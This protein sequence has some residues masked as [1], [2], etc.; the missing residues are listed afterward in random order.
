MHQMK[1]L[2]ESLYLCVDGG[3]GGGSYN[4]IFALHQDLDKA[5]FTCS[6]TGKVLEFSGDQRGRT[7]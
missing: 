3:G 5:P 1:K 2:L 4:V 6:I 7:L